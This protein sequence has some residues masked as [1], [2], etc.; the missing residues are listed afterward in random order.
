MTFISVEGLDGAGGTTLVKELKGIYADCVTTAEPSKRE[1]GQLVR[2]NLGD[3]STDPLVDF[4][5]FMADRRDHIERVIEP[6]DRRGKFVISDRYADSTR[7]YQPITLS[8]ES[9][10]KPFDSSWEAKMF[11]EQT[12]ARWNKEPDLTLYVDISVDTAIERSSG[13]EKYENRE[14]L[15]QVKDNYDAIADTQERV[16]R[17]DGEQPIDEM[18]DDAIEIIDRKI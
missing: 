6:A 5:L 7:A 18:V 15:K 2:R 1:Y 9:S 4:Y 8:G 11:I 14:M 3:E 12:M 10:A 17:V 13:D 16:V